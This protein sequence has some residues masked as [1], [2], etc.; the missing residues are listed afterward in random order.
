MRTTMSPTLLETMPTPAPIRRAPRAV[1]T[2]ASPTVI[3][4]T[5]VPSTLGLVLV[6]ASADGLHAVLLGDDRDALRRDLQA[7]HPGATLVAD[8]AGLA[9]QAAAVV[10]AVERPALAPTLRL[11]PRGTPFQ[12]R[13]WQALRAI[14]AGSTASYREIATRI[15]AP[16]ASR[17]VAGA[18]A[19]NPLAVLVPC[20]RV[21]RSDGTLSGYRWGAA[22]KHALLARELTA[23]PAAPRPS[24]PRSPTP[25]AGRATA[26]A[27]PAR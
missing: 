2:T 25:R 5:V 13:V 10:A 27:R 16:G 11:A 3:R 6:A 24:P 8:D 23:R 21:V 4:H 1:A 7:R 26:T 19:A 9:T 12:Q 15:G 17:A 20:H 18:C 22:R 14:P